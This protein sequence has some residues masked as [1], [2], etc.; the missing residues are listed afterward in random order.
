MQRTLLTVCQ[1]VLSL[2]AGQ[3][4][5]SGDEKLRASLLTKG[6][7]SWQELQMEPR[8]GRLKMTEDY[9]AANGRHRR[10]I[11]CALIRGFWSTATG[12]F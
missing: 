1:I 5:A 8:E 4:A 9:V 7:K 10:L 2:A 11:K 12:S 3:S 6:P